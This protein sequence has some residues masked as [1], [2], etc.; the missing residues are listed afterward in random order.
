MSS[1]AAAGLDAAFEVLA[2]VDSTQTW[3]LGRPA[4]AQH[5]LHVCVAHHQTHGRGRLDRSWQS[6]PGDGL[7]V[8][9]ALRPAVPSLVP[10]VA[11]VAVVRAVRAVL[12]EVSL[13][14]PN[15]LIVDTESS[16]DG[17]AWKKLGGIVAAVHPDDPAVVVVG[18]GINWGFSAERPTETASALSDFVQSV[19]TR[20]SIL[21][22]ILEAMV[23][24]LSLPTSALLD[25]YRELC[26]TLGKAVRVT[27]VTG[28]VFEGIATAVD[29]N[30]LTVES[31]QGA[32]K[33]FSSGDIEQLRNA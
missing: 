19:P 21:I 28:A 25:Q 24:A 32:V 17:S 23:T 2:E 6:A 31:A 14:W 22:A 7:M 29:A 18:I 12:S 33:L 11:G 4:Q 13:K 8:S 1:A 10:L 26:S 27:E 3:L 15:D 9:I 16:A 5:Q 30:G 20:E